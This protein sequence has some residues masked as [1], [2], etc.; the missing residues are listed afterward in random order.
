LRQH[1]LGLGL[2][3]RHLVLPGDAMQAILFAAETENADLISMATHGHGG[4]LDRLLGSV[5]AAVLRAA[6]RPV[7]VTRADSPSQ[8]EAVPLRTILVGLDG[9]KFAEGGLSLLAESGLGLKARILLAQAVESGP[10]PPILGLDPEMGTEQLGTK[11]RQ[12]TER[13]LEEAESYIHATAMEMLPRWD[14]RPVVMVGEPGPVLVDVARG[15]HAD[16]VVLMT[17][18]RRGMDRLQNGSVAG[19]VLRHSS[20]PVLILHGTEAAVKVAVPV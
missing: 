15:E 2:S 7:L 18:G 4:L 13:R 14:T 6:D 17:H 9:S 8:G 19:T 10:P 5:T 16:L 1:L 11:A 12:D 20:A 3:A